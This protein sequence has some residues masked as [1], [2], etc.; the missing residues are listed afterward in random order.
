MRKSRLGKRPHKAKKRN[1]HTLFRECNAQSAVP[2]VGLSPCLCDF[3][4]QDG[5]IAGGGKDAAANVGVI[6]IFEA[7]ISV[8]PEFLK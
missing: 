6:S 3:F 2:L 7:L 8:S 5:E 4:A 1:A